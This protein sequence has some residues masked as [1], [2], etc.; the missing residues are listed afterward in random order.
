MSGTSLSILMVGESWV[1]HTI[2][3]KGFDQF[4]STEYEEGAGVFLGHLERAGHAVTYVRGHEV[5][6]RFPR[7]AEE[8]DAFDVV[9]IS[10]IGA[11]SFQLPDETFLRS[12]RS[13][14]RLELVADF[15]RRGG[16]LVMIG[17]YLSFTGIDGKARFGMS[18]LAEVLPVEM[19]PYDDRIEVSQGATVTVS[20]P[21]HPVLGGTPAEWPELLGYNRLVAKPGAQ[22][23]AHVGEDP[24][25]VVGT[26]GDGRSV[27][28]AS[29]LAPHW[30]PPEFV[31]WPYY[32]PL[33]LSILSWAGEPAR[34]QRAR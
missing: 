8:L 28:F 20:D 21:A 23:V 18:P 19:L 9:V 30:A 17:G 15:V 31:D 13:P 3:M 26:S 1:K 29:D 34:V 16:G 6:L 12:E 32:G 2:H 22:T 33:W 24:M 4:H 14:N 27:A 7:T 10:D 25:L 5:S 11:N